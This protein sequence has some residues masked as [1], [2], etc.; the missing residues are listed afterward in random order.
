MR[1][2]KVLRAVFGLDRETVIIDAELEETG[3][4]PAL[5]VWVR[6]KIRRRGQYGRC[7]LRAPWF[8]QVREA[9]H[10][11]GGISTPRT[12]RAR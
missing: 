9:G 1:V 10:V 5:V 3:L 12:R 4:R 7:Q 8:D 2:K 11:R 6:T